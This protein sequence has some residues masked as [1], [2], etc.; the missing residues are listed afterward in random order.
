MGGV[1]ESENSHKYVCPFVDTFLCLYKGCEG[2]KT[3][4]ERERAREGEKGR[5]G[6]GEGPYCTLTHVGAAVRC[7]DIPQCESPRVLQHTA[8][9]H[10]ASLATLPCHCE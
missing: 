10:V 9:G 7:L 3:E 8:R 4:R 2:V 1:L 5:E 6:G